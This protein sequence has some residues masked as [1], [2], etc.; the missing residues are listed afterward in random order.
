M[1]SERFLLF[2]GIE[3]PHEPSEHDRI[4][5]DTRGKLHG[6]RQEM[7]VAH[8]SAEHLEAPQL[9]ALR[10]PTDNRLTTAW[11]DGE[12]KTLNQE[13]AA[14]QQLKEAARKI[15]ES[16][17]EDTPGIGL[18]ARRRLSR[19][20]ERADANI[21][22]LRRRLTAWTRVRE[23]LGASGIAALNLEG[24]RINPAQIQTLL[25]PLQTQIN[26]LRIRLGRSLLSD[27]RS[28]KRQ[29]EEKKLRAT[30][31]DMEARIKVLQQL[32]QS[33]TGLGLISPTEIDQ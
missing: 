10:F 8:Y 25:N 18:D 33:L 11:I 3:Q 4:V 7:E 15:I 27:D 14:N 12:V 17:E 16:D 32:Q 26:P 29:Q 13:I 1:F 31:N 19:E 9:S 28:E 6:M 23:S 21:A 30:I 24:G 22:V 5:E 2:R 20:S